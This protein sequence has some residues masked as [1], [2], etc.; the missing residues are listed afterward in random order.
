M[1]HP[2][3]KQPCALDELERPTPRASISLKSL[4]RILSVCV[5]I[6]H[7]LETLLNDSCGANSNEQTENTCSECDSIT[8]N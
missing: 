4:A 3:S 5:P 8:L 6:L 2:N 1:T 7:S